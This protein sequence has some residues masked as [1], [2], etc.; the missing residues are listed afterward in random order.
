MLTLYDP[1]V[2]LNIIRNNV[3]LAPP[4]KTNL[5]HTGLKINNVSKLRHLVY[6]VSFTTCLDI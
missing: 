3:I 5:G 2:F 4:P 1:L 6:I